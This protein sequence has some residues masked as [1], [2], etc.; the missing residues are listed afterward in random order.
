MPADD[1][2]QSSKPRELDS[3]LTQRSS[4]GVLLNR[5]DQLDQFNIRQLIG[6]GGFGVVYLAY[7]QTLHRDVALKVPHSATVDGSKYASMY[8]DEARAIAALD[9][10]NIVPA[11]Y[12]GST[13][14][15]ACYIVTKYIPGQHLGKWIQ[16]SSVSF[17]EIAKIVALIADA[18]AY[19]H[20]KGIVHR[21]IKPSNLLVDANQVPYIADFGLA[22]RDAEQDDA[23]AYVGTPP[24]MSPEQAR[25]EGHRVDGRSDIFS[26]GIV[27]YE[28]LVGERPFQDSNRINLFQKIQ[29]EEPLT[30]RQLRRSVPLELERICLKCLAKSVQDRYRYASELAD[31]LKTFVSRQAKHVAK[32]ASSQSD[33]ELPTAFQD[34][35]LFS[36]PAD[37]EPTVDLSQNA[38]K[39]EAREPTGSKETL[40]RIVPK[41]LR[42][43]DFRDAE[44]F[45]QM[46]P[47]PRDRDGIPEVIRFWR[48]RIEPNPQ[49]TSPPVGVLYGPSG[50]GKSS[51]VRAGIMPRLSSHVNAL[52]VEATA[53]DTEQAIVDLLSQQTDIPALSQHRSA[54]EQLVHAFTWMRRNA[55][56]K[57]VI[58]IDQFE[59]WL[60]THSDLEKQS[61]TLALRQCDGVNLQCIVMVRDDFWMGLTRLMQSLDFTIAEHQNAMAVDLFDKRHAKNVLAMFGAAYGRLSENPEKI[62]AAEHRFLDSAINYLSMDGRVV[63]VQL[64]LLAEILKSRPWNNR[65]ISFEDGGLGLGVRFLEDTFDS[66]TAQRRHSIH[67]EGASRLLRRLLPESVSR[68]KGVLHSEREL[69]EACGYG[70]KNAFRELIRILDNELHLITPTDRSSGDSFSSDSAHSAI[71]ETGYQLTHDF[72]I[73][74]IHQ[75]LELRGLGT[76][77]GQAQARLEEFAELYHAR[78]KPQS[79]PTLTEYIT[80]RRRIKPS[81]W[82]EPQKRMMT[83]A[84]RLHTWHVGIAALAAT[85]LLLLSYAGWRTVRNQRNSLLAESEVEQFLATELAAAIPQAENYRLPSRDVA[86]KLLRKYVADESTDFAKRLR[87]S[88]VLAPDDQACRKFVTDFV[89]SEETSPRDVVLVCKS[90][91]DQRWLAEDQLMQAWTDEASTPAIR[92]RAACALAQQTPLPA[93]FAQQLEKLVVLLCDENSLL[94]GD[95]V[96]GF[97]SCSESLIPLLTSKFKVEAERRS[98]A[99]NVANMLAKFAS[100]RAEIL[101][102][103]VE[104]AQPDQ[105]PVIVAALRE[106]PQGVAMLKQRIDAAFARTPPND[107]W[108]KGFKLDLWWGTDPSD[109]TTVDEAT[110]KD[111]P[112]QELLRGCA[113]VTGACNVLVQRLSTSEFHALNS[114]LEKHGYRLAT[115]ATYAASNQTQHMVLWVRDGRKSRFVVG[116]TAEELRKRNQVNRSENYFPCDV[117]AHSLDGYESH[118]Y[119]CVWCEGLPTAMVLDAD[120]Y[121]EVPANRHEAEGWGRFVADN[122]VPRCNLMTHT[123]SGEASHTSIRWKLREPIT[124]YDKWDIPKS[125]LETAFE[126]NEYVPICHAKLDNRPPASADR[127]FEVTWW[128]G[129]PFL[130]HWVDY[131]SYE[132]HRRESKRMFEAGYRPV[133]MDASQVGKESTPL[134]SSVWWIPL[135]DPLTESKLCL[136]YSRRLTALF[137]LGDDTKLREALSQSG[138]PELRANLIDAFSRHNLPQNWLLEQLDNPANSLQLRRATAC[139]LALY[140]ENTLT[141]MESQRLRTLVAQA[142]Q[143]IDDPGLRSAIETVCSR[144]HLPIPYWQDSKDE[145]LTRGGQRMIA[146]RPSKPFLRGSFSNEPGRDRKKETLHQVQLQHPF[147]LSDREI[148]IEQVR[149]LLPDFSKVNDYA[150]SDDCPAININYYDAAKYC[151]L[152]SELEGLAESEMCYPPIDQIH[153]KMVLPANFMDRHGYR[154]PS[155]SEFEYACRANTVTARPFGFAKHLLHEYAWTFENSDEIVHPVAQKLPNDFGFFDLLGNAFEWCQDAAIERYESYEKYHWKSDELRIDNPV[156]NAQPISLARC[157]RGGAFLYQPSNARSGQRDFQ[158]PQ[159]NRVYMSFRIARTMM[160]KK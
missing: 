89:L 146:L 148:T 63:S 18:L 33:T 41:G 153:S 130:S 62:S 94:L 47:G 75:W 2:T 31:D 60:F 76:R 55:Q 77:S 27:F 52:Y 150:A 108:T 135:A 14:K 15:F 117:T 39:S 83:A 122:Y 36:K 92:L 26:L 136:Q 29:F 20:G 53:M 23:I 32:G 147:A 140:L 124:A 111:V 129:A 157:I 17:N 42:S 50:C 116:S 110:A 46:L 145:L 38:R 131:L 61:L 138:E 114:A 51:L 10:P 19:A 67:A 69:M 123:N 73:T 7:D 139:A 97:S 16:A 54:G 64:A 82:T 98:A 113:A 137:M 34:P 151:R 119:N 74:P 105:L 79:L 86:R 152:L 88:I 120:M 70:D 106:A 85:L 9:H 107:L 35:E 109:Q 1:D 154:L 133:S 5:G 132:D 3:D 126:H 11:Y 30:P 72:L 22:L 121:V 115:I 81:V 144:W 100:N 93:D 57:T 125:A 90:Q 102:T 40:I 66:D 8:L 28:M 159:D 141:S 156:N 87:A 49:E 103:L 80:L 95:W 155:E 142:S 12:A 128:N 134:Y 104:D 58:F 37:G 84:H 143:T 101:A 44:F 56:R 21:D 112:L 59:Q 68:I 25:G 91:A 149:R 96:R 4:S 65:E 118:V 45:L 48:S 6:K 158:A 127:G 71:S 160:D 24:Y 13:Q 99:V 78:A 43:F